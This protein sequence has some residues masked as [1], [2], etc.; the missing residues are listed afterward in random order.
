[1]NTIKAIRLAR[2]MKQF[3]LAYVSGV[4][5]KGIS[6]AE[7]GHR[8]AKDSFLKICAALGVEPKDVDHSNVVEHKGKHTW[9][10]CS[11]P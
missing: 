3:Q 9:I 2:G 10:P 8:I 1:M 7:N 5:L 6:K 11:F 4:N